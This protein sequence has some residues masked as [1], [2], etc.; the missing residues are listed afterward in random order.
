MCA[1]VGATLRQTGRGGKN[2]RKGNTVFTLDD[3][4]V[5]E[6]LTEARWKVGVS[7]D[8][9]EGGVGTRNMHGGPAPSRAEES[10]VSEELAWLLIQQ[11]AEEIVRRQALRRTFFAA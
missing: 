3:L 1:A 9:G 8:L 5:V 10:T 4:S 7:A 6:W 11:A 2:L